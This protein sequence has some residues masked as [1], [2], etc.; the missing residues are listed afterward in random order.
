MVAET[1]WAK[2]GLG[3]FHSPATLVDS[4]GQP[5]ATTFADYLLP[6]PTEVPEPRLDHMETLA[7][8]T[9]FGVKGLGEGGAIAPPAAIANA[10][11]DALKGLGAELLYSPIT[12]RRVLESIAAA[13][14]RRVVPAEAR[15]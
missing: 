8:Y 9:E 4:N 5:L 6:G 3:V 10:V 1:S 14:A 13:K 12:P 7:P 11:N 2:P 15:S